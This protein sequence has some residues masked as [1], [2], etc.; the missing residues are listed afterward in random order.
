[1]LASQIT[2]LIQKKQFFDQNSIEKYNGFGKNKSLCFF[3]T[4]FK[5]LIAQPFMKIT[6]K[7]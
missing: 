1:M 6:Q 2:L 3:Y 7:R 4:I 5:V